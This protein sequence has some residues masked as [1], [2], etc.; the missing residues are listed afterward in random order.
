MLANSPRSETR[1]LAGIEAVPP[2]M[3]LSSTDNDR[4]E[5]DQEELDMQTRWAEIKR[6]DKEHELELE[7]EN[8]QRE[9]MR[10]LQNKRVQR[11]AGRKLIIKLKAGRDKDTD[12]KSVRHQTPNHF[13]SNR[14]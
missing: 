14:C 13:L 2:S 4:R 12:L 9:M 3:E 6:L 11:A 7:R 10:E 1:V 5:E 8:N